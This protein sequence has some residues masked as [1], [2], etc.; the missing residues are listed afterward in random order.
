MKPLFAVMLGLGHGLP[1]ATSARAE[2]NLE[3]GKYLVTIMDCAGCHT[4]GALAGKPDPARHLA[5]SSIGFGI[6]GFG[7]FYPPN[8]TPDP[9]TGLGAWSEEDIVTAIRTGM[10][11]DGRG[12]APVM[13][14]HSYSALTDEDALAVA[15]YLKSLPP[16]E[17]AVPPPTGPDEKAPAPYLSV[18]MPD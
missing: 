6:P 4:D 9:K 7:I 11:P 17:H 15:A 10:R 12:L 13:P 3:R 1:C 2:G 14:W 5:G 8:L 16:V 18:V